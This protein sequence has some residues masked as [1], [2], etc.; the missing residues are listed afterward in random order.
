MSSEELAFG[1]TK[2]FI[3]SPKTVSWQGAVAFGGAG[4]W[5]RWRAP[6]SERLAEGG[7]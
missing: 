1:K 6:L 2:I 5:K 7:F 4:R 3:K